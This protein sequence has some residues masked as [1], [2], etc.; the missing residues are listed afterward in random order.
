MTAAFIDDGYTETRTID[1]VPRI[2]P[3]MVVTYRPTTPQEQAAWAAGLQGKSI[4]DCKSITAKMLGEH[5]VSWNFE[6]EVSLDSLLRMKPMLYDKLYQLVF[7]EYGGD[8]EAAEAD[9][10]N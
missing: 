1:A 8:S 6:R 10:K 3:E 5:T 2:H 4:P 7:G 9:A